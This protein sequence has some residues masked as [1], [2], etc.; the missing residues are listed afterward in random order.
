MSARYEIF[1]ARNTQYYFRLKAAN[2]EVILQSEGYLSR[3]GAENGVRSVREH[4]PHDHY[5][6]RLRSAD[7]QHYF[8]L[9][10]ANNEVIGVGETYTT[11][12][13]RD[14]GIE[15]VK[16]NGPTAPITYV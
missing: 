1:L 10:A 12:S 7:Q 3:Q 6:S 13:S 8:T 11:S 2:S 4:S 9:K 16:R 5:Y 14:D 15:S